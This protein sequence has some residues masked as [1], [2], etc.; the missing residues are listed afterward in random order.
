LLKPTYAFHSRE[1]WYPMSLRYLLARHRS[2]FGSLLGA[3][4]EAVLVSSLVD[5]LNR[6]VGESVNGSKRM[7][8]RSGKGKLLPR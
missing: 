7:E 5:T 4:N 6:L 3:R 1:N 2:T 8:M